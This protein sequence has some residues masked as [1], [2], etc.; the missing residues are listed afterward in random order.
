MHIPTLSLNPGPAILARRTCQDGVRLLDRLCHRWLRLRRM[1]ATT[2]APDRLDGRAFS[3][4]H[5][6]K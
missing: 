4:N 3:R 2:R 5:P 6:R 1:Q